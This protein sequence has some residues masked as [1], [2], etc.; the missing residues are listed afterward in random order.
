MELEAKLL[1]AIM[2][3]VNAYL[4]EEKRTDSVPSDLPP[5]EQR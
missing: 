4:D 1:A 2:G 3:A 5:P